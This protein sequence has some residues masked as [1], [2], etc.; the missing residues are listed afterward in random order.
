M[1]EEHAKQVGFDPA[2]NKWDLI[3]DFTSKESG[4]NYEFLE[5][6]EFSIIEK[7]LE[8]YDK[9]QTVFPYPE[10]YGGTLANDQNQNAREADDGMMAFSIHT[11]AQEAAKLLQEKEEA[12]EEAAAV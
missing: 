3:F 10:K 7:E 9:P 5:P 12:E 2:A 8:G 6:S 4:K 11:S 1:L